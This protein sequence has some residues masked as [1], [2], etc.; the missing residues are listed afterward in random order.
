MLMATAKTHNAHDGTTPVE[1]PADVPQE[2]LNKLHDAN[3]HFSEARHHREEAIDSASPESGFREKAVEEVNK[4]EKE[5]ED[6]TDQ[7]EEDLNKP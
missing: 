6:I 5:L 2:L 1:P 4:A 3:Q 7:I